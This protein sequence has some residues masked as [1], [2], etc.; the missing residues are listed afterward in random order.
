MNGGTPPP[1]PPPVI[2]TASI[3]TQVLNQSFS[4]QL[5]AAGGVAPLTWTTTSTLPPGVALSGSGVLSG[6]PTGSA[7][8]YSLTVTV[9][10]A[11]LRSVSGP[12]QFIVVATAGA[13]VITTPALAT[14][15]ATGNFTYYFQLYA[16]GGA[17]PYRWSWSGGPPSRDFN[18]AESTGV[19]S[20]W[21]PSAWTSDN[22]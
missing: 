22:E 1:P 16:Q 9:T 14:G 11:L 13:L 20:I 12:L 6:T 2:T 7:A 10:D 17:P 21:S 15:W 5:Q 4:F 3:P 19:V 18:V 8:T